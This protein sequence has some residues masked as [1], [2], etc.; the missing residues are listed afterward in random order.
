MLLDRGQVFIVKYLWK[1]YQNK[2]SNSTYVYNLSLKMFV[3]IDWP[4]CGM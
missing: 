4:Y 1:L 3:N 2:H